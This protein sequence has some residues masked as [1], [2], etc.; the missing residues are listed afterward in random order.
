ATGNPAVFLLNNIA[1]ANGNALI[2]FSNLSIASVAGEGLTGDNN[3]NVRVSDGSI[4]SQG[5]AAVNME[6][7]GINMAF[8]SINSIGSPEYGIR[9]VNTNQP[10]TWNQFRVTGLTTTQ[11]IGSGGTIQT[12]GEAG[13]LLQNA[14]QVRLQSM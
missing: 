1:G 11:Q 12:A 8:S 14:G 4:T 3:S 13:V 2:T 5:A 10:G 7:S 6:D 9:L